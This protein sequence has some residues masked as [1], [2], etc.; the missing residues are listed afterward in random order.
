VSDSGNIVEIPPLIEIPRVPDIPVIPDVSTQDVPVD[1]GNPSLD[2]GV[3]VDAASLPCPEG[4]C[5]EQARATPQ[6]CVFTYKEYGVSCD[7]EDL[8][9]KDDQCDGVGTCIGI[10]YTC[11]DPTLCIP[12]YVQDGSAC[13]PQFAEEG[14]QCNDNNS[15]TVE[16]QC[17]GQGGC[18][19]VAPCFDLDPEPNNNAGS[20]VALGTI[21]DCDGDGGNVTGVL[22]GQADID[23]Y[24]FVAEDGFTCTSQA[25]LTLAEG[26]SVE[27]CIYTDCINEPESTEVECAEG[28]AT[29]GP[30]GMSGCCATGTVK[31][32]TDCAGFSD[33]VNA[34]VRIRKFGSG[35][36]TC[37]PYSFGY[38]N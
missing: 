1:E 35:S 13:V 30:N 23:W 20:A 26:G 25:V 4:T 18:A 11:D 37:I 28:A 17:D 33:D 10:A 6:G 14:T 2:E 5:I 8:S 36:A 24:T 12:E 31:V 7:D 19:G 15:G 29:A 27:A 3:E 38:H 34:Y 9:T 16:D 22:N 21:G 32:N